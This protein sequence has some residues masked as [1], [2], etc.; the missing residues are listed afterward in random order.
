MH[1]NAYLEQHPQ[2]GG[3][4]ALKLLEGISGDIS[5]C[6]TAGGAANFKLFPRAPSLE[7]FR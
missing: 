6:N 7:G 4:P 5:R 1:G 3:S 2:I